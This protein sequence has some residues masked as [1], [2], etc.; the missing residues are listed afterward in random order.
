MNARLSN[1]RPAAL[2]PKH[3]SRRSLAVIAAMLAMV[4]AVQLSSASP[5]S[6]SIDSNCARTSIR[7]ENQFGTYWT[8]SGVGYVPWRLYM[9][10]A[11]Y[12]RCNHGGIS[13]TIAISDSAIKAKGG[14]YRV[15][16]YYTTPWSR[17]WTY[18]A[19]VLYPSYSASGWQY[20]TI[21]T[22]DN[23]GLTRT[24]RIANVKM[25]SYLVFNRVPGASRNH[26]CSTI[27]LRCSGHFRW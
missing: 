21:N 17:G 8:A 3:R 16:F 4:F 12:D 23:I 13:G 22:E 10:V 5:A 18:Q 24:G 2:D 15:G 26:S 20:Y 27:T 9:N 1:D 6:A 25:S 19:L 11:V 14:S 7:S